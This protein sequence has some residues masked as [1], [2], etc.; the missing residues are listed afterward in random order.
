MN[1]DLTIPLLNFLIFLLGLGVIFLPSLLFKLISLI[2]GIIVLICNIVLIKQSKE[3]K[4]ISKETLEKLSNI[5]EKEILKAKGIPERFINDLGDNPIFKQYIDD[6]E[7]NEKSGKYQEAIKN[8]REIL[9]NSVLDGTKKAVVYNLI[10]SCYYQQ[11]EN[12]QATKSLAQ[13]ENNLRE[14]KNKREKQKAQAPVF[15]NLGLAN[16]ALSHFSLAQSYFLKA[17]KINKK[18]GN[19]ISEASILKN[20]AVLSLF[21]KNSKKFFSYIKNS[22]QVFLKALKVRTQEDFPMTYATTQNNLGAAYQ[23]LAEVRDKAQNAQLAKES[24]QR[25]LRFFNQKEYPE[26]HKIVNRNILKLKKTN[27]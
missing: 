9:I 26:A 16:K 8:Y 21:F 25:A 7:K 5:Q 3:E 24:Y 22:I 10:G 18:I 2:L 4:K 27:I 1:L 20:L 17:L 6:G 14:I 19:K 11:G 13:A 12:N 15:Y 23:T